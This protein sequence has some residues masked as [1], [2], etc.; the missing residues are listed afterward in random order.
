MG[1][2]ADARGCQILSAGSDRSFRVFNTARDAQSREMSRARSSRRRGGCT[3]RGPTRR[4]AGAAPHPGLCGH[5]DARAGLGATSSPA[6]RATATPTSGASRTGHRQG[7]AAAAGV[8]GNSMMSPEAPEQKTVS[9]PSPPAGT[10]ARGHAWQH[11]V[12]LTT[13]GRGDRAGPSPGPAPRPASRTDRCC[14]ITRK[15]ARLMGC[16]PGRPSW[17]AERCQRSSSSS[18]SSSSSRRR[19]RARSARGTKAP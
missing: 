15:A 6:T 1:T 5:R 10:T 2:G 11:G 14:W 12:R 17:A 7:R 9:W 8:G 3:W 4:A 13:C 16:P 19:W 18:S